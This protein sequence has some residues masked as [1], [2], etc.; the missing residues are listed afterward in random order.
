MGQESRHAGP[1]P[2]VEQKRYRNNN[3]GQTDNPP[4]RFQNEQHRHRRHR[5]V[6]RGWQPGSENDVL[7]KDDE[8]QGGSSAQNCEYHV[9]PRQVSPGTPRTGWKQ[10]VCQAHA[11]REVDGPL[12]AGIEHPECR[13]VKLKQKNAMRR[14]AMMRPATPLSRRNADSRS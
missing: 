1:R 5:Q 6:Q 14:A 13:R 8:I 2:R 7:V 4:C 10:K 11:E 9:P 3:D 12:D